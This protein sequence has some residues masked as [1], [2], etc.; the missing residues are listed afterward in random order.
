MSW[1]ARPPKT[2]ILTKV[3]K[4]ILASAPKSEWFEATS[5]PHVFKNREAACERLRCKGA[6]E[7][8]Y[9]HD[10][11]EHEYRIINKEQNNG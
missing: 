10:R 6:L 5:L 7:E 4:E 2:N 9:N 1:L 11:D 8:R 3:E